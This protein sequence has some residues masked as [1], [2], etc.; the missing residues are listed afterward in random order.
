MLYN[1]HLDRLVDCAVYYNQSFSEGGQDKAAVTLLL[2]KKLL[3][4]VEDPG[5]NDSDQLMQVVHSAWQHGVELDS[6][7]NFHSKWQK[8]ES[9]KRKQMSWRDFTGL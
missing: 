9:T 1:R 7:M 4:T 5:P 2:H 3:K 8:K 6:V